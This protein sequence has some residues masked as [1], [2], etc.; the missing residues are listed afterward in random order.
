MMTRIMAAP[1][2]LYIIAPDLWQCRSAALAFGLD[3]Q[4]MA[5]T[6]CITTAYQLRGTRAG[7]PFITH[8]R[9]L[10]VLDDGTYALDQAID[11]LVRIGRLRPAS[12]D[13]IT[14]VRGES[15][16]AAE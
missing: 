3:P 14:A 8:N 7:T 12:T 2:P 15:V 6:R 16:E 10:W 11:L 13:D 9:H 5:N 1:R 4:A